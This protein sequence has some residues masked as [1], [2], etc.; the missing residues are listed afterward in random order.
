MKNGKK[1]LEQNP[2]TKNSNYKDI[3]NVINGKTE[4]E[5]SQRVLQTLTICTKKKI[6]PTFFPNSQTIRNFD[7]KS[8]N[9]C[10]LTQRSKTKTKPETFKG[11]FNQFELNLIS[12]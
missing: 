7:L 5:S 11:N 9:H 10:R 8:R 12:C 4:E 3:N 2:I 6:F 1:S